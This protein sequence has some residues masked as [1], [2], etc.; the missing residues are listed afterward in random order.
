MNNEGEF[1]GC[2]IDT[3]CTVDQNLDSEIDINKL[4]V[5]SLNFA[6]PTKFSQVD[7]DNLEKVEIEELA[8]DDSDI[9]NL[10][11]NFLPK[12]LAPLEDLFDFNDV[13][14]KPKVEP[15]RYDIEECNIGTESKP[16]MIKLSKALQEEKFKY[17]TLIKEF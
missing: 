2:N 9:L 4:D 7:I 8:D 15:L 6:K 12:G 16:K 5:N 11:K 1:H 14:R 10:K 3:D 13:A 17:I